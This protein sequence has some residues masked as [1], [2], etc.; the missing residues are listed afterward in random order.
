M[1]LTLRDPLAEAQQELAAAGVS[2][3]VLS[4]PIEL[5]YAELVIAR[6][7]AQAAERALERVA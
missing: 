5:P 1:R 2:A 4:E 6:R 7:D 3:L